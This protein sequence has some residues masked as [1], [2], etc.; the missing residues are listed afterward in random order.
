MVEGEQDRL[1]NRMGI[2]QEA[3]RGVGVSKRARARWVYQRRGG[4]MCRYGSGESAPATRTAVGKPGIESG[5]V[6]GG[7]S[8]GRPGQQTART[9]DVRGS[10][11]FVY[12]VR[13][14]R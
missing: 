3:N 13:G 12:R 5:G 4:E 7:W 2:G 9:A 8:R 10:R 1:A 6:V 11:W 14:E